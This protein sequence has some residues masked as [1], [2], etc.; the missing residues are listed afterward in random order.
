MKHQQRN[1]YIPLK[2]IAWVTKLRSAKHGVGRSCT[3]IRCPTLQKEEVFDLGAYWWFIAEQRDFL[4][5]NSKEKEALLQDTDSALDCIGGDNTLVQVQD[6]RCITPDPQVTKPQEFSRSCSPDS[7]VTQL[8]QQILEFRNQDTMP[9]RF[10]D[11][12]VFLT[13]GNPMNHLCPSIHYEALNEAY[14]ANNFTLQLPEFREEASR[15][16]IQ[17]DPLWSKEITPD[18][19]LSRWMT[20]H[21]DVENRPTVKAALYCKAHMD[22]LPNA[23]FGKS[24]SILSKFP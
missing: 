12:N 5:R 8:E 21:E 6:L 4:R 19:K 11:K 15:Q 22:W 10:D 14:Q 1:G 24:F 23:S 7:T 20:F 13:T 9:R 18:L 17:E 16:A 2:R 3:Q